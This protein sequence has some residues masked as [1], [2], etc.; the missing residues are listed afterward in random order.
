MPSHGETTVLLPIR[1][2][3]DASFENGI[4]RREQLASDSD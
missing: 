3:G 4:K 1:I 2:V